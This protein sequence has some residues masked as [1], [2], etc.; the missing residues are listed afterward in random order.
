MECYLNKGD[1]VITLCC[2]HEIYERSH[3]H[4]ARMRNV[5]SCKIKM[6]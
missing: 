6:E 2:V 1:V 3:V 5:V 4:V